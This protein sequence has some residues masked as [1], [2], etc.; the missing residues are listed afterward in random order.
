M[1]VDA[2]LGFNEIDLAEFRISYLSSRVGHT[3]VGESRTTHSGVAKNLFFKEWYEGL[4]PSLKTKVT[5]VE[6]PLDNF[7]DSWGRE[8]G[9]REFLA[10]YIKFNFP[11][12]KFILSDLDEI[13][14]TSQIDSL[15]RNS[16]IFHFTTPTY[17]RRVNLKF[18]DKHSTWSRGVCGEIELLREENGG[19]FSSYPLVDGEPGVHLSYLGMSDVKLRQKITSFAHTELAVNRFAAAGIVDFCDYF[20]INHL[21]QS[22]VKG[23]GLFEISEATA[24][25]LKELI[26]LKFSDLIDADASQT[27]GYLRRFWASMRLSAFLGRRSGV[28]SQLLAETFA[29]EIASAELLIRAIIE[30]IVSILYFCKR[31]LWSVLDKIKP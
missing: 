2:F 20:R 12:A 7:S 23:F 5:I 28:Q 19:R 22:R 8:I 24:E 9:S 4:D 13:P 31:F 21:G 16:G 29:S 15:N 3:V 30:S 1:I 6:I 17:Y 26:R 10:E 27:P 25:D 11:G 18:K 14:S